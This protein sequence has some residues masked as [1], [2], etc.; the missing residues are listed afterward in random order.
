MN[1]MKK[2]KVYVSRMA[3]GSHACSACGSSGQ[4]GQ[5][6]IFE[7]AID[8][9][10]AAA[11][12]PALKCPA[13]RLCRSCLEDLTEQAGLALKTD[14]NGGSW[15]MGLCRDLLDGSDPDGDQLLRLEQ[16]LDAI[17]D[18]K[19]YAC[20]CAR[21]YGN[22]PWMQPVR[23][24]DIGE[25]RVGRISEKEAGA[26]ADAGLAY[27]KHAARLA[28]LRTGVSDLGYMMNL[29]DI[30]ILNKAYIIVKQDLCDTDE[31]YILKIPGMRL[32]L[33]A[34]CAIIRKDGES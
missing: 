15:K 19:A 4:L 16:L 21:Y 30:G 20:L 12:S 7:I 27:L 31:A 34:L 29:A 18:N 33:A 9:P 2:P 23:I 6:G 5:D 13:L 25:E 32:E 22:E 28:Y 17:P 24:R 1:D 11:N 26:L 8:K 10:V 3:T 14:R